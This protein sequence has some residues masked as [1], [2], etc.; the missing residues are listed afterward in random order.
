MLYIGI[1]IAKNKHDCFITNSK[2]K[3]LSDSF[4]V[5]NS[6]KGFDAIYKKILFFEPNPSI[7]NTKVGLEATGHYSNNIIDF[8]CKKNL[9]PVVFNPLHTNLYRKSLSLRKIKTDKSDAQFI[10]IMLKTEDAKPYSPTS[11][12]TS[13]LKALSRN[14]FR[15]IKQCS[16]C[17]V[18]LNRLLDIIFPELA[19][20][21][22][23]VSQK[24]VILTLLEVPNTKL[25]ADCHLNRLTSLLAKN[26]NRM[27]GK[28]KAIE[29]RELAK[30]SI[31][32]NSA[33]L[34]FELQQT[35]RSILFFQNE[36]KILDE[37]IERLVDEIDSPI[38][39]IPGIA[40]TLSAMILSEIGD[41]NKF[42]TPSKLLA[43]A[44]LE[45]S[46]HQSG[47]YTA[48][49]NT[50]VKRGSKYLRW[51]L[52]QAARQVCMRSQAFA[53]Y[54]AKKLAEGKHFFVALSHVSKKLLRVIF[55]LLKSGDF[56]TEQIG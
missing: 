35:I 3:L 22:S 31:G 33:A 25:I 23:R 7:L 24:S 56:Y 19:T 1:D 42:D 55:H 5:E 9:K 12:H 20:I 26:S 36:I 54:K 32:S 46:T 8:F 18:A 16:R 13:E 11:Y 27:Y 38:M 6:I 40:Y 14:R 15:L 44:G 45:P 53:A 10:T 41:I 4:V 29:F 50:M 49:H 48:T 51:A 52:M 17:K 21:V 28:N 2:G 37:Q 47:N 34:A 39:T 30:N 43:F